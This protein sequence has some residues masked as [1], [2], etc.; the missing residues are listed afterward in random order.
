MHTKYIDIFYF[1]HTFFSIM[2][3]FRDLAPTL[4]VD[5]TI[6]LIGQKFDWSI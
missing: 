5:V 1:M 6:I 3:R 2:T 4:F